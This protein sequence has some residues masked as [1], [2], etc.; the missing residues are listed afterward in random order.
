[1]KDKCVSAGIGALFLACA[2]FSGWSASEARDSQRT[3]YC[4]D[5]AGEVQVTVLSQNSIRA[6]V[7]MYGSAD[8]AFTMTMRQQGRGFHYVKGEYQV[9][10]NK[11]QDTLTYTAPDFGEIACTWGG[12]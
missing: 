2:A 10:I 5:G 11:A 12:T 6:A 8:G 1:M 4:G 3:F 9:S 7:N